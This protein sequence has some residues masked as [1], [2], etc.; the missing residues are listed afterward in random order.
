MSDKEEAAP[1]PSENS[2]AFLMDEEDTGGAEPS[3]QTVG[4]PGEEVQEEPVRAVEEKPV[5]E[6][7]EVEPEGGEAT[8]DGEENPEQVEAEQKPE[9]PV[10]DRGA[11]MAE[12]HKR[13]AA[14]REKQELQD[15]IR[16][17]EEKFSKI[18]KDGQAQKPI[19]EYTPTELSDLQFSDPDKYNE[20]ITAEAKQRYEAQS[21]ELE[22]RRQQ[23]QERAA[24]DE[25]SNSVR[26]DEEDFKQYYPDYSDAFN[27]LIAAKMEEYQFYGYSNEK[28]EDNVREWVRETCKDSVAKGISPAAVLYK[29][30]QSNGYAPQQFEQAQQQTLTRAPVEQIERGRQ[31]IQRKALHKNVGTTGGESNG[32]LT[33]KRLNDMSDDEIDELYST[34]KGRKLIQSA[35]R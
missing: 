24:H 10:V 35:M 8:G 20:I 22:Q 14:E 4:E 33:L 21:T 11:L 2:V 5:E 6:V 34:D 26:E 25:L 29:A 19:H 18:G 28:A 31:A 1:L 15:K 12:R 17:L 13:R 7:A 30:A 16:S 27:S 9:K 32:A 3:G 23:D